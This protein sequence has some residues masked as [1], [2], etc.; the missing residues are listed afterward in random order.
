MVST[1]RKRRKN[2]ARFGLVWIGLSFVAVV[3]F[4]GLRIYFFEREDGIVKKDSH[5]FDLSQV[6]RKKKVPPPPQKKKVNKERDSKK[7]R[8][9]ITNSIRGKSFG[10][11]AFEV[12]DASLDK[13][14]L[15]ESGALVM[16]EN[17][18]DKLP[19]VISQTAASFPEKAL[20]DNVLEGVVELR[21]LINSDGRVE[22][23]EVLSANPEG[24]FEENT[25]AM[26]DSWTFQPAQYQGRNVAIWV[27]QVVRFGN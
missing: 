21:M 9:N 27:K 6:Q 8:P 1:S 19:Q 15:G 17:S 20:N 2:A 26:L 3:V 23:K 12:F 4:S 5:S 10:L 11:E 22:Q 7:L 24:Y 16:D 13:D 25:L 18:V 14:L